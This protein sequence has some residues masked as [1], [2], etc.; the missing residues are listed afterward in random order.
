MKTKLQDMREGK[1]TQAELSKIAGLNPQA[2]HHYETG[3]RSIEGCNIK[4]LA[5]IAKALN[6]RIV[7]LLDDSETV[8]LILSLPQ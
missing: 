6:C 8:R 1:F 4:A 5:K 7:D 2:I 3:F